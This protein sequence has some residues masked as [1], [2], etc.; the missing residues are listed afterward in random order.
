[1]NTRTHR[2][3]L[4]V[5][6]RVG[7][8]GGVGI[9]DVWTGHAQDEE[10][11]RDS[12]FRI[13]G[14]A[15]AQMQAAFMLNWLKMR[16]TLLHG[17]AYFPLLASVGDSEAQVFTSSAGDGNENAGIMYLLAIA[18]AARS[19]RIANAYFVPDEIAVNTLRDAA[20]RGVR[21]QILVPGASTD[22]PLT[23]RASRALWGPL[24]EAG[25]EIYEYQPTM[26][27]TKVM[28]VDE[29][30]ASVGSTN[31]D[32]RSFRLNDEANLNVLNAAFGRAEASTFDADLAQAKRVTLADW[33]GRP[34]TEKL[35]EHV[36]ATLKS[37]L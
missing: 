35:V 12:H 22:V 6:G 32:N 17:D 28:V 34:L 1:M 37:Q 2:R 3:L 30:F 27:H 5:D 24:L 16:P 13:E 21:V 20:A 36:S 15:V 26:M 10:H 14:P 19:V 8:T 4:V 25:I 18:S 31:F 23:R 11:W 33:E 9:A 29:T 7:F